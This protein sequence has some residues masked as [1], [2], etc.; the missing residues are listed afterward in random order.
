MST[1][2]ALSIS[3]SFS[4]QAG[5]AA[6][7]VDAAELDATFAGIESWGESVKAALDY[8]LRSDGT[9]VDEIVRYRNLH[10]EVKALLGAPG[11]EG[12][13]GE[14]GEPGEPGEPGE[15]GIPGENGSDGDTGPQGPTGPSGSTIISYSGEIAEAENKD[16]T[17]E[18]YAPVAGTINRFT[19]KTAS[20]TLTAKLQIN[21]VDVT[22]SSQSV[23]STIGA[24]TCTAANVVAAG[25]KITMVLS[26]VDSPV[27]FDFSIK[28]TT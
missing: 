7:L 11:P 22:G 6:D 28:V 8:L 13:Q 4:A 9:M 19:T 26:S 1:V 12:P 16:Y 21:G 18:L 3:W 14:Q 17:I 27:D 15:Q 10:P 5:I 23:T 25:D 2:P 20:G 24:G